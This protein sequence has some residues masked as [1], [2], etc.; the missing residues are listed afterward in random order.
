MNY[1]K[2]KNGKL[3][4]ASNAVVRTGELLIN[5]EMLYTKCGYKKIE[6]TSPP[7]NKNNYDL[8]STWEE[9]DNAIVQVWK[10]KPI[11]D[12]YSGEMLVAIRHFIFNNKELKKEVEQ[13]YSANANLIREILDKEQLLDLIY[14]YKDKEINAFQLLFLL[15]KHQDLTKFFEEIN[16]LSQLEMNNY[17][18]TPNAIIHLTED[19]NNMEI[20]K[21]GNNFS[22]EIREKLKDNYF[23]F[24]YLKPLLCRLSDLE[25]HKTQSNILMYSMA[26]IYLFTLFD[27]ILLKMIRLVCLHE[28]NWLISDSELS[29]SEIIKCKTIDELHLRLVE[30]K[31]TL[32]SWGSYLDK[33]DFLKNRGIFIS[34]DNKELFDEVI[35]F[36]SIK[37]NILVHNNGIWSQESKEQLKKT[38][39]YNDIEVNKKVD[40]SLLSFE[41]ASNSIVAAVKY[42]YKQ[43]CDKFDFLFIYLYLFSLLFIFLSSSSLSL[44]NLLFG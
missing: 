42:L 6:Y 16:I 17:I 43:I 4:L 36:L 20:Q 2:I 8:M 30:K 9:T 29:A 33:L 26:Y 34:N 24:C 21:D 37:R 12:D 13:N 31:V 41:E 11:P 15:H 27:E 44:L 28:K 22:D 3:I 25:L 38:K 19:I 18:V 39:Y 1:G 32:L 35:L 10:Y 23:N 14:Q 5:D 40:Y 7:I